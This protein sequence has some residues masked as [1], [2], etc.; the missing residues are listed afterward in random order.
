MLLEQAQ[1]SNWCFPCCS[2]TALLTHAVL[3]AVEAC[4]KRSNSSK[5]WEVVL[6]SQYGRCTVAVAR[7]TALLT[8]TALAAVEACSK[9]TRQDS[10]Q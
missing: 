10:R 6:V 9:N 2:H 4:S 3:A 1:S 5:Q 8:H 7:H